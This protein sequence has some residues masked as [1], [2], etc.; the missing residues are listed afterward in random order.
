VL[1]DAW[2]LGFQRFPEELRRLYAK[3]VEK[4]YLESHRTPKDAVG[5]KSI[6]KTE[7]RMTNDE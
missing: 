5:V 2:N 7:Q 1:G 4:P 3:R 6:L